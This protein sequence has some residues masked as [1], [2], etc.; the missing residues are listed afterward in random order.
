MVDQNGS[1]IV[2]EVLGVFPVINGMGCSDYAL[3]IGFL[4]IVSASIFWILVTK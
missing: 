4:G 3:Y 2:Q 1:C